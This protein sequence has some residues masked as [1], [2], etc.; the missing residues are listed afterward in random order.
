MSRL[1]AGLGLSR[2]IPLLAPMIRALAT[3]L[4]LNLDDLSGGV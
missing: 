1:K 2:P 4:M 3:A